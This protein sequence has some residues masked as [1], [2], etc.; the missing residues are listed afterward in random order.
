MT[1]I[2]VA[3]IDEPERIV[4]TSTRLPFLV[5]SAF[6]MSALWPVIVSSSLSPTGTSLVTEFSDKGAAREEEETPD[7]RA[8]RAEVIGTSNCCQDEDVARSVRYTSSLPS[9]TKSAALAIF[10]NRCESGSG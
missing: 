10:V 9:G 4:N 3:V 2:A 7:A 8:V 5:T 6:C 1:C